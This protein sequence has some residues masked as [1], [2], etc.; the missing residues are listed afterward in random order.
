MHF[1]LG[2]RSGAPTVRTHASPGRCPIGA[3]LRTKVAIEA[4]RAVGN[5]GGEAS[6]R[7]GTTG[8]R[9]TSRCAPEGAPESLARLSGAPPGAHLLVRRSPV[10]ALAD[11]LHHRLISVV[12]PAPGQR[13]TCSLC[14]RF[15]RKLNHRKVAEAGVVSGEPTV[16]GW[17]T[18]AGVAS[19][20]AGS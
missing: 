14:R 9:R 7:A 10:V 17:G 15:I 13:V 4:R 20:K 12:P 11:S 2:G 19:A 3:N 8:S 1:D 18:E 6:P 16:T 5:Y